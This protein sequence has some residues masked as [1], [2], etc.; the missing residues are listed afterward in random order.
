LDTQERIVDSLKDNGV[1]VALTP[2]QKTGLLSVLSAQ[3]GTAYDKERLERGQ[4][5][6]NVS[7]VG[8]MMESAMNRLSRD[9][10]TEPDEGQSGA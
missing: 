2:H 7:L 10:S 3:M 6:Q 5:T 4:S 8:R 1:L 9:A